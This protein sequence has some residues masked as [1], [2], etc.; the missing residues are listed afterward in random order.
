LNLYSPFAC[1]RLAFCI[2]NKLFLKKKLHLFLIIPAILPRPL[3]YLASTRRHES[4]VGRTWASLHTCPIGSMDAR[5]RRVTLRT[6]ASKERKILA[7]RLLIRRSLLS[8]RL[9]KQI[10]NLIGAYSR[11]F[12]CVCNCARNRKLVECSSHDEFQE[13]ASIAYSRE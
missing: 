2:K 9:R 13:S 12:A 5:L 10:E 8:W 11:W 7:I 1:F 6:R 4:Y 3:H